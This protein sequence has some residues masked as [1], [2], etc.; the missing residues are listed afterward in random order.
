LLFLLLSL[1]NLQAHPAWMPAVEGFVQRRGDGILPREIRKHERPSD[2]LQRDPVTTR[3]DQNREQ[4]GG[5]ATKPADSV[6]PDTALAHF[7]SILAE[8]AA[9]DNREFP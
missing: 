1:A 9:A 5:E 6:S 3:R 4:T 8:S 2:G 7:I